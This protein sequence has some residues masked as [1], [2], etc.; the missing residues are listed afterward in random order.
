MLKYAW[1]DAYG[2][3]TEIV[4]EASSGD[5]S[6]ALTGNDD[7]CISYY[8]NG[9]LM[10]AWN[11]GSEW[12]TEMVDDGRA[13]GFYSSLEL[14]HDDNPC[15]A[16]HDYVHNKLK[17]AWKDSSGWQIEAV[18]Y[19]GNGGTAASLALD[20]AG[21]P[22][23]CYQSLECLEFAW[24]GSR[25]PV[26]KDDEYYTW[27]NLTLDDPSSNVL[28]NDIDTNTNSLEAMLVSGTAHG[29]VTLHMNGSFVY[30]P[31]A[32]YIG[33]DSFTYMAYNGELYS[34][35]ATVFLKIYDESIPT[36]EFPSVQLV[37]CELGCVAFTVLLLRQ[38]KD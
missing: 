6:L 20:S 12:H 16:Y 21:T 32:G 18:N 31:D 7:P 38:K 2:W 33:L 4:E 10:Y 9:H 19:A 17:Y 8:K 3:H 37:L 5:V 13:V 1:K 24:R 26:A 28:E 22:F 34:Q 35:E 36:P 25:H 27:R 15:V 11:D 29:N 23:I 14:D 30:V